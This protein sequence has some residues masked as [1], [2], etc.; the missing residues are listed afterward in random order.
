VSQRISATIATAAVAGV[1][2][3]GIAAGNSRPAVSHALEICVGMLA[4]ATAF[5]AF[6]VRRPARRPGLTGTP[7]TP[8]SAAVEGSRG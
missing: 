7:R 4:L 1:V 8:E 2:L 5:A 6:D 3:T